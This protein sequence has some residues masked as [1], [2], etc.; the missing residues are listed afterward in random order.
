MVYTGDTEVQWQGETPYDV[1]FLLFKIMR[2]EWRPSYR[3]PTEPDS[4]LKFI[5]PDT[6]NDVFADKEGWI[7]EYE[8]ETEAPDDEDEYPYE[9]DYPSD[10]DPDSEE[11]EE[12]RNEVDGNREDFW[13]TRQRFVLERDPDSDDVWIPEDLFVRY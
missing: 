1:Q 8:E 10:M 12:W 13:V 9:Y 3:V 6:G 7:V 4:F 11:A 2:H 5:S